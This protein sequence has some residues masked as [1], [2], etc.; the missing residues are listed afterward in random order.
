VEEQEAEEIGRADVALVDGRWRIT[1]S[2]EISLEMRPRFDRVV[3]EVA[4]E[5][6]PV[7]V[8]LA[9]V[10]F[11]D[12]SGIAFLARL[13]VENPARVRVLNATGL[14]QELLTVTGLP[15]ILDVDVDVDVDGA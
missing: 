3:D 12:S 15:T 2:G 6:N 5:R 13:A 11:M 9:D 7:D 8:D 4:T 14:T 1:L 10:S